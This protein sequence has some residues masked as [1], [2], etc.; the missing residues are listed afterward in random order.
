MKRINVIRI[1]FVILMIIFQIWIMIMRKN[2][3]WYNC[4]ENSGIY[5]VNDKNCKYD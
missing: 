1:I 3:L 2:D 4:V 5:N